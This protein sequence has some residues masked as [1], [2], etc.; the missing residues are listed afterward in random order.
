MIGTGISFVFRDCATYICMSIT[1]SHFVMSVIAIETID[2]HINLKVSSQLMISKT[3]H[4]TYLLLLFVCYCEGIF[5][6]KGFVIKLLQRFQYM[7][8]FISWVYLTVGI[9]ADIYKIDFRQILFYGF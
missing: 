6:I 7:N 3:V 8:L 9:F 5:E 1:K 4:L 2:G